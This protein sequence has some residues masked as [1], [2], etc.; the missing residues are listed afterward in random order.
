MRRLR[1]GTRLLTVV[2]MAL[3]GRAI[4]S[5]VS[6]ATALAGVLISLL[7]LAALVLTHEGRELGPPSRGSAPR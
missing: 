4:A 3:A 5:G 1:L 6:L 2:L 7:L